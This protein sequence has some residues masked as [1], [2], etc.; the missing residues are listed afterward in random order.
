LLQFLQRTG[1]DKPSALTQYV[2]ALNPDPETRPLADQVADVILA[3]IPLH[4]EVFKQLRKERDEA[5]PY[6]RAQSMS[7]E[8]EAAIGE[9]LSKWIV[10]ERLAAIG[11][12]DPEKRLRIVRY[13]VVN[14]QLGEPVLRD[15]FE[16]LRKFRNNLVHGFELPDADTIRRRAQDLDVLIEALQNKGIQ[17]P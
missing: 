3:A 17:L 9:F 6:R 13:D 10:I 7:Q 5:N 14:D 15:L 2:A 4:Y 8:Q 11:R 16:S 12:T 1:L